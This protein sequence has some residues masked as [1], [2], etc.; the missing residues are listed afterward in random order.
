MLR[1]PGG[2]ACVQ[3]FPLCSKPM[4]HDPQ[5]VP[6]PLAG[7]KPLEPGPFARAASAAASD[8]RPDFMVLLGLLPPYTLDAS[9]RVTAR[10]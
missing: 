9:G 5:L 10:S 8:D 6:F 3:A 2:L 4:V 7:G 1:V